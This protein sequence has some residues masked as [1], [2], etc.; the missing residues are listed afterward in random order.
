MSTE[1]P[2][3][4]ITDRIAKKNISIDGD[5]KKIASLDHQI[6][7]YTRSKENTQ[8]KIDKKQGEI[9]RMREI[10]S[11]A[12]DLIKERDRLKAYTDG[13]VEKYNKIEWTPD[14]K[15]EDKIESTDYSEKIA[16]RFEII[17][18]LEELVTDVNRIYYRR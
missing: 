10:Q 13:L 9:D 14:L 11:Q 4:A 8:E 18:K 3:Q 12:K 16:E 15:W 1:N 6:E 7:L 17:A 5:K 2:L